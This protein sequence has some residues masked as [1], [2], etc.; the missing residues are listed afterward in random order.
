MTGDDK[1]RNRLLM[2]RWPGGS[3]R[4]T[5]CLPLSYFVLLFVFEISHYMVLAGL[6][7]FM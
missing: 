6:E 7:L 4:T 1:E 3:L 2:G 5:H